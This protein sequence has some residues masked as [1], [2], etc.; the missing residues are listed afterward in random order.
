MFF[1]QIVQRQ[2]ILSKTQNEKI[3]DLVLFYKVNS[4]SF[5]LRFN[6]YVSQHVLIIFFCIITSSFA[7]LVH[8]DY[9]I[10]I[11]WTTNFT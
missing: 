10:L 4:F 3:C 8:C 7:K 5:D 11:R 9:A 6:M 2:I 1:Y